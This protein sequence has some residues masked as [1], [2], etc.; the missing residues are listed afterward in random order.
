MRKQMEAREQT[1]K[2]IEA[3]FWTLYEQKPI[4]KIGIKEITD[5]A[6]YNRGTFYLYYKDIYDLL[7]MVEQDLLNQINKI[8]QKNVENVANHD[9]STLIKDV[10][11][12]QEPYA[13]Y[14]KLL[15]GE[16]GDPKYTVRL[17]EIIRPVFPMFYKAEYS[18][19]QKYLIQEFFLS[20]IIGL[21]AAWNNDPQ[22]SIEEFIEF[23]L[24]KMI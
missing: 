16:N 15:L 5:L 6:N 7:E 1:K 23:G 12:L 19:Y 17:K 13:R 22:I 18:E 4:E 8:V 20:G 11:N 3:A 10:Y 9:F 14:N 2:N 24:N 21:I